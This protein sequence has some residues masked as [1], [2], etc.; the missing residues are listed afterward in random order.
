MFGSNPVEPA[1]RS[2]MAQSDAQTV[3]RLGRCKWQ[4]RPD[5][6]EV[7]MKRVGWAV[8]AVLL[9]MVAGMV[10]SGAPIRAQGTTKQ[11]VALLWLWPM[12]TDAPP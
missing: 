7:I 4:G 2:G 6:R 5:Q 10:L 3:G 12:A 1:L 9:P 11:P 8:C